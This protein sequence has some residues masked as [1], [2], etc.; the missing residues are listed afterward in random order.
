MKRTL[1]HLLPLMAALSL[2]ACGGG[3]SASSDTPDYLPM[4][5]GN[6]WT[7]QV[8]TTSP[9]PA[10][11]RQELRMLDGPVPI[12]GSPALIWRGASLSYFPALMWSYTAKTASELQNVFDANDGPPF[13]NLGKLTQ[14][15]LPLRSGDHYL[16]YD[17]SGLD[18]G[19]DQDGDGINE[20]VAIRLSV[21]V[22][23][24]EAVQVPAGNFT[25]ALKVSTQYRYI[26]T[27]SAGGAPWV[28]NTTAD[29]WY[30]PGLGQ[31]KT[32]SSTSYSALVNY[33]SGVSSPAG[34]SSRDY[35][36][37]G[38]K[39]DGH[40]TDTTA[41]TVTQPTPAS[42]STT[43]NVVEVSLGFSEDM[44]PYSVTAQTF[45]VLDASQ[46]PVSGSFY[47]V[48]K[49]AS[50]SFS[51]SLPPGTYTARVNDVTDALGNPLATPYSWTFN[52]N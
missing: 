16:A 36:L 22:G 33:S 13:G 45:T 32:T 21:D 44:D 48:D 38:Y 50:L 43:S 8:T 31:I 46:H 28:V 26:L 27:Y 17:Y 19:T 34:S 14:L 47:A 24:A 10:Q 42:N 5:V 49:R 39:I 11:T 35:A 18:L 52:V 30:V 2:T 12:N 51:Q 29:E 20:T 1:Q 9:L 25:N 37:T 3:G 4:S 41:P 40:S 23:G 6:R 15:R 7:Y